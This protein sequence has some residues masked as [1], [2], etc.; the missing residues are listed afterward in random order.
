M[1]ITGFM[2]K[3]YKLLKKE[4]EKLKL[5]LALEVARMDNDMKKGSYPKW[6]KE[7]EKNK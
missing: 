2:D 5:R 7:Y 3:E 6:M 4:N 1:N